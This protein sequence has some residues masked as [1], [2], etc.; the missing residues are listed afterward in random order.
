[1]EFNSI[2]EVFDAFKNIKVLVIG[3]SMIDTYLSGAVDRISPEAPVPIVTIEKE[4]HRLGGAANVALNLKALGATPILASIVGNDANAT[5][6]RELLDQQDL[7]NNFL[8]QVSDRPTTQKKRVLSGPRHLLRMDYEKDDPIATDQTTQFFELVE[9]VF[10]EVD[11]VVVEDYDKGLLGPELIDLIVKKAHDYQ[12]P[13]CVDPKFRNFS[14]YQKV[15][16][17][18]PNLIELKKGLRIGNEPELGALQQSVSGLREKLGAKFILLT[19]GSK[20]VLVHTANETKSIPANIRNVADVSGAG[21]TVIAI[22]SLAYTLKLPAHVIA[23]LSNLGGG[24][25]CEFPGVIPVPVL[26]LQEE[27]ENAGLI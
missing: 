3:D 15:D 12:I 2:R 10:A 14:H 13:V 7:S 21:D 16:L 1:M 17:F 20:G 11:V 8:L 24:I 18:K 23:E 22:A 19:L 9:P 27:A 4:E 26:R 25:V 6:F 5:L